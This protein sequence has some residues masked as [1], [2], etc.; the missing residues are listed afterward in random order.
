MNLESL[1]YFLY[2]AKY[3]NM[4]RAANYFYV[5]QSTLSRQ[6][7]SLESELGVQL[8]KRSKVIELTEAGKVL[9]NKVSTFLK[10][11]HTMIDEVKAA[12]RGDLGIL[13][14]TANGKL[15]DEMAVIFSKFH[16][17][18]PDVQLILESYDFTEVL[19]SVA[20]DIYDVAFTY[21]FSLPPNTEMTTYTIANDTF[22]LVVPT[23]YFPDA[24]YDDIP[25]IVQTLPLILPPYVE[26]PFLK[27]IKY[28]LQT[29]ANV[30]NIET[31]YVNNTDSV[32]LDVSLGL[33]Y[34]IVPT[35]LYKT[36]V[37]NTSVSFIDLHES[38]A[39][40]TIVMLTKEDAQDEIVQSFIKT[41]REVCPEM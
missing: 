36:K 6:I 21:D 29:E 10:H 22:S 39:K 24:C 8:F 13:R 41:A 31:V 17:R 1:E 16:E 11:Y 32:I 26:P 25:K 5:S 30:S 23:Q 28:E 18:C 37:G 20:F 35:S 3:Q 14:I 7:K 33:G 9:E 34:S 4:T 12:S 38:A 15:C 2:I 19:S 40:A 27:L